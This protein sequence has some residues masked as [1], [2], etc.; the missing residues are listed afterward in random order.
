VFAQRKE[1]AENQDAE[2]QAHLQQKQVL[3]E[4]LEQAARAG[5]ACLDPAAAQ[6]A[7]QS[8]KAAWSRIGPVP[9]AAERAIEQRFRDASAVLQSAVQTAADSAAAA[10]LDA[11]AA[12]IDARLT[13]CF[14][15]DASLAEGRAAAQDAD[16]WRARWQA[17]PR[18]PR[19]LEQT[20]TQRFETGLAAIGDDSGRYLL[21]LQQQRPAFDDM[22]LEAEIAAGLDSPPQQARQRMQ[23]QVAL[24]QSA[25]KAG[26]STLSPRQHL[27]RLCA[28]PVLADQPTLARMGEVVRHALRH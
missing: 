10:A 14:A 23:L 13:L 6:Q 5:D 25:L 4:Q 16:A 15:L 19:A 22:L 7:L 9:R 28:V 3:C 20:L 17:A 2:R 11:E 24:L 26:A 18:L 12:A 27:S 8:G 21:H 1:T